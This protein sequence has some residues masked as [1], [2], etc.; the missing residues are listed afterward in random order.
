M[1]PGSP[2]RRNDGAGRTITVRLR[3]AVD[4]AS[5]RIVLHALASAP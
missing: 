4:E 3:G 1:V 5:I 2:T